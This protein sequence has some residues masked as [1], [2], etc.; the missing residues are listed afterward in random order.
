VKASDLRETAFMGR[1]AA[2]VTHELKNVLAIIR[3]SAGLM[4]DLLTLSSDAPLPLKEK[5][6]RVLS[7][8][9]GQVVRGVDLASGLN[10]FAHLPDETRMQLDLN[11]VAEQVVFL[12][13][14][15]ARLRGISLDAVCQE[16][17]ISVFTDPLKIQMLLFECVDVLLTVLGKGAAITLRPFQR[18]ESEAAVEISSRRGNEV[19]DYQPLDMAAFSEW[20]ELQEIARSLKGRIEALEEPV[21]FNITFDLVT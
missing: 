12:S 6:S 15:F 21:G 14:R 3:E 16:R 17:P 11:D 4:Q 2:G 20:V 19:N 18:G 8:I 5:F 1:I 7:N 13:Q 9:D 10:T